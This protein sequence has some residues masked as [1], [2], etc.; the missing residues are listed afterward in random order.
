MDAVED[1]WFRFG[2]PS[3]LLRQQR[4]Q[5]DRLKPMAEQP[6]RLLRPV[7]RSQA[8]RCMSRLLHL[9]SGSQ[10]GW[11]KTAL[12]LDRYC[13][14]SDIVVE[15]LPLTCVAVVR[16]TLK[17]EQKTYPVLTEKCWK[18]CTDELRRWLMSAGYDVPEATERGFLQQ[19]IT[20]MQALQ[21]RV[22]EQCAQQWSLTFFTRFG[23]LAGPSFQHGIQEVEIKTLGL[24]K[25]VIMCQQAVS[26]LTHEVL[27]LGLLCICMVEAGLVPL[28]ELQP[29]DLSSEEWLSLYLRT[30]PNGLAP[31]CC[32]TEPQRFQILEMLAL[33]ADT[34]RTDLKA[35]AHRAGMALGIAMHS[36]RQA[37]QQQQQ[38]QRRQL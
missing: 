7:V 19:E 1:A 34:Q 38:Q 31:M 18:L 15:A 21:W 33:A 6:H 24:A 37:Q 10:T 16:I 30:Q 26:M 5:E 28:A 35:S 29:D 8:L 27:V 22:E 2:V 25:V 9:N 20:V 13:T 14:E 32:L 23:V 4:D 3:S 36:M 12:L 11:C 17:M